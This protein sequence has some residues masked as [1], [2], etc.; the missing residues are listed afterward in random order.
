M[1]R[2]VTD[3][4][5]ALGVLLSLLALGANLFQLEGFLQAERRQLLCL[6]AGFAVFGAGLLLSPVLG[7]PMRAWITGCERVS[8][9]MC[10]RLTLWFALL[11]GL[12]EVAH[13]ASPGLLDAPAV[14]SFN[15]EAHA[16]HGRGRGGRADGRREGAHRPR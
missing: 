14:V 5:L 16:G 10:L 3:S 7:P 8:P 13:V 2:V 12:L 6:A 15:R 9:L 4:L 1:K 11:L